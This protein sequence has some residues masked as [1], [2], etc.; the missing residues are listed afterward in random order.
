MTS[1]EHLHKFRVITQYIVE[2]GNNHMYFEDRIFTCGI[3]YED[4][5]IPVEYYI[6]KYDNESMIFW[7]NA[8]AE[9]T[10]TLNTKS[11]H[12]NQ[13]IQK[14]YDM[15]VCDKIAEELFEF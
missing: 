10:I 12:L 9:T 3:I 5:M 2:N 1:T 4:E 15:I 7:P 8:K 14:V 6:D 13:V 11:K